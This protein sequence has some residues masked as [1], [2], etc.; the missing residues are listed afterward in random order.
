MRRSSLA[1]IIAQNPLLE[2]PARRFAWHPRFIDT[3][4]KAV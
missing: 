4:E 3:L 2:Q 1:G